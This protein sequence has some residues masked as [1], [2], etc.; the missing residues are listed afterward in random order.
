MEE[1]QS[2]RYLNTDVSRWM[3]VIDLRNGI[4]H[5]YKFGNWQCTDVT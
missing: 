1:N 4:V 2:I 5:G 3:Y